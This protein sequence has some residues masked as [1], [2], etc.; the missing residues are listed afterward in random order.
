MLENYE[1]AVTCTN[2]GHTNFEREIYKGT[3][4]SEIDCDNCGCESLVHHK[5]EREY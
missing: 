5:N 2:C 4:I 1:M 3:T